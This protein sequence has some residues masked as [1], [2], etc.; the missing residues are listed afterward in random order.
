MDIT[1]KGLKTFRGNE[2][3]GFSL[4]LCIDGR[5]A[6]EVVDDANG[7][8]L[9]WH[10]FS[11]SDRDALDAFALAL[12]DPFAD[13][14]E[15][16]KAKGEPPLDMSRECRA[17]EALDYY[18]GRLVDEHEEAKTIKRWCRTKII[19]RLKADEKGKYRTIAPPKGHKLTPDYITKAAASLRE[20]YGDK[21]EVIY[22]E[23]LA[24]AA[25]S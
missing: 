21:L 13:A 17:S 8:T 22:N 12:P 3:L 6:G 2:G 14:D 4:W 15:E 24:T 5:K 1:I 23:R 19:F 20:K 7:G 9:T 11:K 10:G 16:R 25:V 18:V